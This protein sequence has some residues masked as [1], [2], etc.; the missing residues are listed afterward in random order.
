MRAAMADH[1][2]LLQEQGL[3]VPSPSDSIDVTVLDP[4]A[5]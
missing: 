5:A 3:P 2:A 1:L 4:A